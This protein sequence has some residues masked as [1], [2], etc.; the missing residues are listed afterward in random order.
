MSLWRILFGGML[1]I[2]KYG[3]WKVM[4]MR[5]CFYIALTILLSLIRI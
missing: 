5:W 2:Q 3:I 1:K 4:M